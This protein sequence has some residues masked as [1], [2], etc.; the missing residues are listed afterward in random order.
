MVAIHFVV[1]IE[2]TIVSFLFAAMEKYTANPM[3]GTHVAKLHFLT[4]HYMTQENILHYWQTRFIL[5]NFS[6]NI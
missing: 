3:E 5:C 2:L 6:Q 1:V 4:E